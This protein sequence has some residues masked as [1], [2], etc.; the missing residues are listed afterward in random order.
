MEITKSNPA[1][2]ER[3]AASAPAATRATTQFGSPAI[4][5]FARTMMSRF[6]SSSFVS[7]SPTYCI[8]PSPFLSSNLIRLV[9]SHLVNH[10]G[11]SLYST[12][13]T[14]LIRFVFANAA[15]AGAVV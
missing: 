3:A 14:V 5:G 13:L 6:T 12:L 15:T 10:S 2:V 7:G 9:A 1:A 8:S 11:T 4:S